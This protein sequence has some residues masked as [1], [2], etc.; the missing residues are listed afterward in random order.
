MMSAAVVHGA[1]A[2]DS[3]RER[4]RLTQSD[5]QV[6]LAPPAR[7][8]LQSSSNYMNSF[9]L[10]WKPARCRCRATMTVTEGRHR[11]LH[12]VDRKVG[13]GR[14]APMPRAS[15]RQGAGP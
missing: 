10:C 8:V 1:V 15:P 4:L 5:R 9:S 14:R 2:D 11:R 13:V 6:T 12:T 7:A 3:S